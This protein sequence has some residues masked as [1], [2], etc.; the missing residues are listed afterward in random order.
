MRASYKAPQKLIQG[1]ERGSNN[2]E[3]TSYSNSENID[4]VKETD[5]MTESR[6]LP[7]PPSC[8]VISSISLSFIISSIAVSITVEKPVRR[9][10]L[11][12]TISE[13]S[14]KLYGTALTKS[15]ELVRHTLT[16][17]LTD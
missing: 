1:S 15:V 16:D 17:W 11:C 9:E 13:I 14:G 8:G 4:K 12:L 5:N 6:S 3:P 7:S 2:I 10:F